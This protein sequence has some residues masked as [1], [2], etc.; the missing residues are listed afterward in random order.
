MQ[1]YRLPDIMKTLGHA[2]IDILKMDIEANEF[3]VIPQIFGSKTEN[4]PGTW[5][6]QLLIEVHPRLGNAW[7]RLF[8]TIAKAGFL[9]FSREANT[10]C[11]PACFEYSFVHE[12]CLRRYGIRP[13]KI[14]RNFDI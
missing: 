13:T 8:K 6:C 1:E 11:Q 2:K 14:H 7:I 10:F 4:A 9:M 12:T 3:V 5:V